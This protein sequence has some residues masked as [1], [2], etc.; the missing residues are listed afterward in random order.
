MNE[1]DRISE[2]ISNENCTNEDLIFLLTYKFNVYSDNSEE[3]G[4]LCKTFRWL[5]ENLK[6]DIFDNKILIGDIVL[7]HVEYDEGNIFQF[8]KQVI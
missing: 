3:F 2:I 6:Y 4:L 5:K 8:A 1:L 7:E